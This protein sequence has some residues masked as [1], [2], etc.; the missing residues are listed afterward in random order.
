MTAKEADKFDTD[1][2]KAINQFIA[3]A[4]EYFKKTDE[5]YKLLFQGDGIKQPS[6]VSIIISTQLKVDNLLSM[7]RS[8]TM[9]IVIFLITSGI[10]GIIFLIQFAPMLAQ[11]RP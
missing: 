6:L 7:G 8:I 4:P 9:A 1:E 3:Y 11:L 2:V 10:G 5:M